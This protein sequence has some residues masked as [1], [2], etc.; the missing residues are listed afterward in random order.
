MGFTA[1]TAPEIIHRIN[2]ERRSI[3]PWPQRNSSYE[4]NLDSPDTALTQD[5][6]VIV[7]SFASLSTWH[8]LIP[9]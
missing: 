3:M 1:T 2:R 8:I 7:L 4:S 6:G 5:S 9:L